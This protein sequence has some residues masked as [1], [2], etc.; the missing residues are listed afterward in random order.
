MYNYN[1]NNYKVITK[2]TL[3]LCSAHMQ[4]RK[5]VWGLHWC[6]CVCQKT[7]AAAFVLIG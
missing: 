2:I 5:S 1:Y 6:V 7:T 4:W 3:P